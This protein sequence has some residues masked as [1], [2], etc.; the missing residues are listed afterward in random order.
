MI[1]SG[2]IIENNIIEIENENLI[3]YLYNLL[4]QSN[5]NKNYFEQFKKSQFILCD[6]NIIDYFVKV[7]GYIII[8][9]K[10]IYFQSELENDL[11]NKIEYINNGFKLKKLPKMIYKNG[12]FVKYID[13]IEQEID[14]IGFEHSINPENNLSF[15]YPKTVNIGFKTPKTIIYNFTDREIY[16]IKSGKW[17]NICEKDLLEKIKILSENNTK[18]DLNN[19]I[20]IRLGISSNKFNFDSCHINTIDELY[21]KLMIIFDD[22]YFK[23]EWEQNI[24]LVLREYI[25]TNYHRNKIYNGLPLN[26][27]FRVFYDFDTNEVLGIF[28]YWDK[29]TML[30]NLRNKD[31]ITFANTTHEI[32][33][34]F[35]NLYPA[36]L[37]Q[38][39]YKLPN[40]N[41]NGKWS[42]DFLYDG[43]E[44][45]LIDMAHAE[46]SYYYDKILRKRKI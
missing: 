31:L 2:I 29:N 40:T 19:E 18:L 43:T 46:C 10:T 17:S 23:L 4:E 45:I 1:K 28:N 26:T 42:I 20:F 36:L 25:K 44:F 7:L 41:L 35:N 24:E 13:P 5:Q 32:E 39:K 3:S 21:Q 34:D 37:E 14:N 9:D 8:Y 27:E 15:W 33:T 16:L 30:D 22:M 38:V 11:I 12:K 6:T